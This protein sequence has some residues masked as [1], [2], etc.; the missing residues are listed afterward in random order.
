MGERGDLVW[1]TTPRLVQEAATRL[2][3]APAVVDGDVTLSFRQLDQ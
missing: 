3:D 1:G 2:G